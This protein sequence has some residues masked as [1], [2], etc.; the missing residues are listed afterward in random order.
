MVI[1]GDDKMKVSEYYHLNRTQPE[2]D[3]VD[4]DVVGDV[5]IFVDPRALRLLDS[6]WGAE[7]RYL[8]QNCFKTVLDALR[9]GNDDQALLILSALREPN[10]THLGLSRG[11]AQGR[12]LGNESAIDVAD[13]LSQSVAA[14]T[15]LLEDLEDTI[16]M[17]ENIGPDI[18]SDM[19]TNII[20]NPLIKYTQ[21]MCEYYD[22]PLQN[23]ASGRL[24]N[25][26]SHEWFTMMVKQPVVNGRRLLL[27]PKSIVRLHID[28][29][30]QEYYRLYILEHLRGIELSA[31]TELVKLL[32]SGERRVPNKYLE[33]KYGVGKDTSLK[34][35]MQYPDIL[36][37]Y[38]S[39]K[40]RVIGS[41]LSHL[42]LAEA[43]QSTLPNWDKLL[44]D[45]LN[46]PAGTEEANN[47][48]IRIEKILSALFS[49]D[50]SYPEIERKI[51]EGRKRIDITYTN[52]ATKGFFKWVGDYAPAP[53][54]FIECKNYSREIA[55]PELDQISGRFSPRRGKFGVII[56]RKLENKELFFK[57]CKDTLH[58]DRG[59]IIPLDDED[60]NILIAQMKEIKRES[61]SY[62]LLKQIA[63]NIIL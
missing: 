54:V 18:I 39:D 30:P 16:L 7:C 1:V 46:T 49:P 21:K 61:G 43:T 59:L 47:Y 6:E 34:I 44:Q 13:S 29:D 42:E 8:I 41:P 26:D 38:R 53:Y 50:L 31:N 36:T 63:D 14:R 24:W 10:E 2:L 22:I 4:V 37:K 40:N 33:K 5:R 60:L 12:A 35:T 3:F 45:V 57:R 32:K 62:P 20:R 28:Y 27:V 11:R 55:N 56:C 48:H 9:L 52:V 25:P 15:G 19:T 51:H 17:V 58:D 23:V